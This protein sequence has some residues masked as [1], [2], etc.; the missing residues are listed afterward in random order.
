MISSGAISD[1][2][3]MLPAM[4]MTEPYSPSARANAR[5]PPVSSAGNTRQDNA[6]E[7]LA[8]VAPSVAAASSSSCSSFFEHRLQACAPRTAGR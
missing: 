1:T 4:K 3:G 5:A 8:R 2:I 6:P 7:R